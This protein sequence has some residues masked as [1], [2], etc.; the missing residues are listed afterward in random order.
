MPGPGG[1]I[2]QVADV[3]AGPAATMR[4]VEIRIIMMERLDPPGGRAGPAV[5]P[6]ARRPAGGAQAGR[7]VR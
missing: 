7:I 1:E 5:Q 6:E 2:R 4:R 3:A